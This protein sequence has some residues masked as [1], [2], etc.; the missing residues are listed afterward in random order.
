MGLTLD[1]CAPI[2]N[3]EANYACFNKISERLT[4]HVPKE[5][6]A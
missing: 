2:N 3:N 4:R 6:V 5:F 1:F